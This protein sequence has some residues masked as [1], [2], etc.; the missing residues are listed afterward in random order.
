MAKD[1]NQTCIHVRNKINTPSLPAV[2][3]MRREMPPDGTCASEAPA[4][5][6]TVEQPSYS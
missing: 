3:R 1:K 5:L 6:G 4:K 2:E